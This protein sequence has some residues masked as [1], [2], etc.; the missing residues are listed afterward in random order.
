MAPIIIGAGILGLGYLGYKAYS[1]PKA[2]DFQGQRVVGAGGVPLRIITRI[3]DHA[4]V[5]QVQATP[6]P[7]HPSPAAH[8]PAPAV[9]QVVPGEGTVYAPPKMVTV[10]QQG[11]VQLAPIIIS[12]TGDSSVAIGSTMDV[13]K[14]L[15][16]LGYQPLLTA[17]GKLGPKTIANIRAFQS[18]VGIV[19]D[20][21]A[22]P[23]TKAALSDTLAKFV[24]GGPTAPIA[25]AATTAAA[26]GAPML[27]NTTRDVQHGLNLL[28]ASPSL[29]E[30][31]KIGP[32]T[33]AA[34]KSF[35]L[36]HGLVVDG[37]AGAKTKAAIGIAVQSKG[38]NV[39]GEYPRFQCGSNYQYGSS[40]WGGK[41]C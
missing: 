22:G 8:V 34:I 6:T 13:Q 35:Q 40:Q 4:T 9:A 26:S 10:T 20:G 28:G 1:K 19:V 41:F 12:P 16:T 23:A 31:G 21:S 24:S 33:V 32:K 38:P 11:S 17:D 14:A 3:P 29:Q 39:S 25:A 27:V 18:K 7:P 5:N 36:T 2:S 15:N 37:V 30:D